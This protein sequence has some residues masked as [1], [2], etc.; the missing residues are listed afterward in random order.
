MDKSWWET[1]SQ[2][3]L[4]NIMNDGEKLSPPLVLN[5]QP[6]CRGMGPVYHDI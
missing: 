2:R 3:E 4:D 5:L 1:I 6:V